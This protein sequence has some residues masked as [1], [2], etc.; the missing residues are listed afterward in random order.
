MRRF[1]PCLISLRLSS[2]ATLL[3]LSVALLCTTVGC[4]AQANGQAGSIKDPQLSR[5]IEVLVRSKFSVPSDYNIS[6][7]TRGPSELPGYDKLQ[8]IIGKGTRTTNVDFLISSDNNKL[9]RLETF[10]LNKLPSQS[11]PVTDR[12][13]R[14]NPKAKVTVINFDDLE[15]PYCARMHQEL[16]PAALERYKDKVRFIYKDDPLVEIHPWALHAAV[17]SNCLAAQNGPAY[18]GFVDYLHSHGQ[19]VTGPDRNADKSN[20]ALDNIAREQGKI[21]SLDAT[22][23]DACLKKQDDSA[24]KTSM[25]EAESLGVEGTPFLFVDGERINGAVPPEQ[26]W[27]VI[28]RALRA[29][30]VEPPPPEQPAS[31]PPAQVPLGK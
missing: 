12:P 30:G 19:E 31:P 7:G 23:L 17:D 21:F 25:N 18:W 20:L 3:A 4:K 16:F 29:A 28:D 2:L 22:K 10:D 8:V 1:Y 26:L 13:V 11:I 6:F 15:C 9:A 5:R 27:N 14:G 24:V